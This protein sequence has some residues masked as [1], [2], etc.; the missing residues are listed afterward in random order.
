LKQPK[1]KDRRLR[2]LVADLLPD[3]LILQGVI[4]RNCKV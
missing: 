1:D 3:K 2:K 4:R